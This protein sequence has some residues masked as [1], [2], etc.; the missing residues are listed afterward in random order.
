MR[1]AL[2][3]A[4]CLLLSPPCASAQSPAPD[5]ASPGAAD[6]E[7]PEAAPEDQA[8]TTD[9]RTA[10][11]ERVRGWFDNTSAPTVQPV[12]GVVAPGAGLSA[13]AAAE[14]VRLGRTPLGVG[15][16]G[17]VSIR[18][19]RQLAVRFGILGSRRQLAALR[20]WDTTLG[21]VLND[22]DR[23]AEGL[24]VYVEHQYRHLPGLSLF[25]VT[26]GDLARTDFGRDT[27]GTD[28]VLQWRARR[29]LDVGVR[30][31][32]TMV[33][34]YAGGDGHLVN[35]DVAL[36]VLAPAL[37]GRTRYTTLGAGAGWDGRDHPTRPTRGGVAQLA[38]WA[39]RP[40][41]PS[42]TAFTRTT[43][44][45]RAYRQV[46]SARH[47]LAAR[48]LASI[49]QHGSGTTVPFHM[50]QTLGGSETL[51]GFHSYRLRG[52]RLASV[53]VESRWQIN[54]LFD[55]VPFVDLGAVGR[56]PVDQRAS[57][58][59]TSFG[60][61]LRTHLGERAVLRTDIAASREGARFILT[62]DAPF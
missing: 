6:T 58:L 62:L 27:T 45:L 51:R 19:Y 26:G 24:A 49:D 7:T 52:E 40:T 11:V 32:S 17:M 37:D 35:T 31:G 2:L 22:G 53:S 61:G 8:R 14:V 44:D 5:E 29:N 50:M 3:I 18:S 25:G 36:P 16:D 38:W 20:P 10:W 46:G 4:A 21:P 33:D 34:A 42:A 13:G 1:A 55:V 43:V 41:D 47:V 15:V 60:A 39:F 59:L 12:F 57:G 48:L 56:G 23:E 9:R 28:V 30:A 54:R